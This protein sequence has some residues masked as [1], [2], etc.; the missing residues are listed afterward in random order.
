MNPVDLLFFF[1]P[2]LI[3]ES[4]ISIDYHTFRKSVI[5]ILVL[6]GPLV[7]ISTF[8]TGAFAVY[9]FDYNWS[10]YTGLTFGA[11]LSATGKSAIES[12]S[13]ILPPFLTMFLFPL[14]S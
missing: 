9:C 12:F 8:L 4:S 10:W 3:F 13:F 6:A 7:A 2:A 11:M 14:L 1:L 5:P